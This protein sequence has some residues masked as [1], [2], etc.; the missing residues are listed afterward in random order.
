MYRFMIYLMLVTLCFNQLQAQDAGT[1]R[2]RMIERL[3]KEKFRT[4][5]RISDALAAY[6]SRYAPKKSRASQELKVSASND[7]SVEE[8]EA[9][10][11]MDPN[12]TNRLALSYMDNNAMGL[13]FPI[14]YSNNG[15]Q[16]W[17][18]SSF[19]SLAILQQDFGSTAFVAGGGDPIFAYDKNGTL[20]FSWIYVAFDFNQPDT[21]FAVM[22]LARST[23]NGANWTLASGADRFI[24]R[25]S[26]DPATFEAFP[27]SDGFYDRQWFAIDYS[28]GSNANALYCSFVY[29]PNP[30]EPLTMTGTTVKKKPG[31][32]NGF[33]STKYQVVSGETQFGNVVVDKNGNLHVTYAELGTN[34]IFHKVSTNGGA[35]FSAPHQIYAGTN[36]FGSQGNGYI[37]DRENST[38]NLNIDGDGVL[39]C[40]WGD[41]PA[42]PGPGF[43]SYYSRSTDGGNTWSQPQTLTL[44]SDKFFM[45]VVSCFQKKV[46]IGAYVI[47]SSKVSDYYIMTSTDNGI[48]FGQPQKI[49]TQSTNFSATSNAG[50]WFGDYYNSVRSDSKIYNIWSDGR[51]A[52]GPKMYVSVTS[53]WPTAVTEITPLN[54]SFSLEKLYPVPFETMLQFSLKSA[55][56]GKL[57]VTLSTLEGRVVKTNHYAVR[58]GLTDCTWNLPELASGNY[59]LTFVDAEGSRLSRVVS[60]K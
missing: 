37:H 4:P 26:L 39:H 12:N 44:L 48:N 2:Q 25:C 21:A 9:H 7:P 17:S 11:A 28:N 23:D 5:V 46:T 18:L 36:L 53:E 31:A 52:T 13:A 30:S 33:A 51:N 22:Y 24:G 43:N 58:E 47:N 10:I 35:S 41:F 56:S 40:V 50:K 20:W 15:G 32:S 16:N 14:Y 55:V 54:A 60:K 27:N 3:K 59:L 1:T 29:F 38:P 42:T 57:D 8:G 19:N 34:T 6:E 45:P 49:S